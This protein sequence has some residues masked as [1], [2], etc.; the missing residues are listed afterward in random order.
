[1]RPPRSCAFNVRD[2]ALNHGQKT[3]ANTSARC[4]SGA[5]ADRAI[6]KVGIPPAAPG[7]TPSNGRDAAATRGSRTS[8][9]FRL[10]R[11]SLPR[12]GTGSSSVVSTGT[13]AMPAICLITR[14]RRAAQ[15]YAAEAFEPG[16]LGEAAAQCVV[17]CTS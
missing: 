1:M 9:S 11:G 13:I 14:R 4:D 12:F 3:A 16:A 17:K 6:D 8:F 2:G 7:P 5:P 15:F 10:P